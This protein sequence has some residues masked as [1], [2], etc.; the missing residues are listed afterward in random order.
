[1]LNES[2]WFLGEAY[3]GTEQPSLPLFLYQRVVGP[4]HAPS[5]AQE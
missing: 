4:A 1:M 2:C 3:R 5:G